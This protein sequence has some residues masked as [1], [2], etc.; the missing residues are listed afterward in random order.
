MLMPMLWN[1]LRSTLK[2]LPLRVSIALNSTGYC[3]LEVCDW[4]SQRTAVWEWA[5]VAAAA[6]SAADSR[7]DPSTF[8]VLPV[9]PI[10]AGFP[11]VGLEADGDWLMRL[12]LVGAVVGGDDGGRYVGRWGDGTVRCIRKRGVLEV[13]I[14][15]YSL[16]RWN[17]GDRNQEKINP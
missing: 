1:S 17:R 6:S 16:N 2:L 10:G 15:G 13:L 7:A 14:T 5:V 9:R 4:L 8:R 3:E 11:G 12:L